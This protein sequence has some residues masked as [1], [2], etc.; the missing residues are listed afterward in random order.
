S[1]TISFQ[2][3]LLVG[4]LLYF[5]FRKWSYFEYR[6]SIMSWTAGLIGLLTVLLLVSVILV[7]PRMSSGDVMFVGIV[8]FADIIALLLLIYD[9]FNRAVS[10]EFDDEME[11]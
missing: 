4:Y 9:T 2:F 11:L 7:S 10:V 5:V 1:I 6:I 3:I 8:V